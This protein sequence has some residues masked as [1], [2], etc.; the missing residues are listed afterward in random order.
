MLV[1]GARVDHDGK[2]LHPAPAWLEREMADDPCSVERDKAITPA[3]VD[4]REDSGGA[5]ID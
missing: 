3:V 2:L 1:P 4:G 5:G